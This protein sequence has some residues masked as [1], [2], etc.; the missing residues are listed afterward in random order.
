[1]L[2]ALCPA[3]SKPNFNPIRADSFPTLH[4]LTQTHGLNCRSK[5]TGID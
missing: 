3:S 4:F 5:A 2:R 1:M